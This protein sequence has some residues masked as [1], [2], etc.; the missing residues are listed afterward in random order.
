MKPPRVAG[1]RM[2][3]I[4]FCLAIV[5]WTWMLATSATGSRSMAWG[6]ASATLL[7]HVGIWA[8]LAHAERR[9]RSLAL[10]G[11]WPDWM[12]A[13][14]ERNRRKALAYATWGGS[15][16]VAMAVTDGLWR[17]GL[18]SATVAF[19]LGAFPAGW[20]L[21]AAQSRVLREYESRGVIERSP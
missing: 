16:A 4:A 2:P 14:A 7:V 9:A 15:M 3:R 11:G 6:V 1:R 20:L 19:H 17:V 18:T 5:V 21:I 10:S 13:Q 8:F 12:A